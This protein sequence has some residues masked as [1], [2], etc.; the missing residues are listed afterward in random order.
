MPYYPA[1]EASAMAKWILADVFHF[2][3]IELYT[4]KDTQIPQ[5]DREKLEDILNR[6]MKYEPLQYILGECQFGGLV[7]RVAPGVLIP[8]SSV[9]ICGMM[10]CPK[11]ILI[12]VRLVSSARS[13]SVKTSVWTVLSN[14]WSVSGRLSLRSMTTRM[15]LLP[16]QL[17]TVSDGLSNSAVRLPTRIALFSARSLWTYMEV[18]GVDRIAGF[19]LSRMASMNPSAD[20]AHFKVM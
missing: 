20:S 15:G 3:A 10:S 9:R 6:L 2:S 1:E 19:P 5:K 17:R 4:G 12:K 11:S 18:R 16:C 7:F 13:F 14:R 8:R